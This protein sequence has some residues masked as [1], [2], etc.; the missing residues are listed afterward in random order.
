[1]DPG[2]DFPIKSES[3]QNFNS[4]VIIHIVLHIP[5]DSYSKISLKFPIKCRQGTYMWLI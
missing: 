5:N 1:M 3:M 2:K 4:F